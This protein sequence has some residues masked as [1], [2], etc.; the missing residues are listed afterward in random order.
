MLLRPISSEM[1]TY[2]F[3][4]QIQDGAG[5]KNKNENLESKI[6]PAMS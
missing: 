5:R 6:F 2:E 4:D 3:K 1:K